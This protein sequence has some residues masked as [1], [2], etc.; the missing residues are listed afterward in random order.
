MES[1]K[2]LLLVPV[3][4]S[5]VTSAVVREATDL[6]R[7]LCARLCLLHAIVTDLDY[8]EYDRGPVVGRAAVMAELKRSQGSLQALASK[9]E[10]EGVEVTTLVTPG[11]AVDAILGE[12]RR[13]QARM[14]VMGSHGHGILHAVF[15][16]SV[17][18][19]VLRRADCPIT[20]VPSRKAAAASATSPG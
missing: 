11:A 17:S 18:Q 19:G 8:V 1:V 10:A 14:I 2:Q 20:F 16:G 4:F 13:Q 15:A 5:P 9:V 3:D 12:A 7:A 6:A